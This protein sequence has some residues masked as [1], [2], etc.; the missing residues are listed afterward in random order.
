M[1]PPVWT[2]YTLSRNEQLP[3]RAS[4]IHGVP[5]AFAGLRPAAA[6]LLLLLLLLLHASAG[7]VSVSTP[8]IPSVADEYVPLTIPGCAENHMSGGPSIAAVALA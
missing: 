4:A 6:L 7:S 5:V 3:R 2:L 8:A 1:A